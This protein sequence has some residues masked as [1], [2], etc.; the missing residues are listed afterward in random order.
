M[1]S[2][3]RPRVS[4]ILVPGIDSTASV[5]SLEQQTETAWELVRC[6]PGLDRAQELNDALERAAGEF[7]AFLDAGDTLSPE[8]MARAL[9]P[10]ERD[11]RVDVVYTD[12]EWSD[13]DGSVRD[14]FFKP[15]WSPERLLGHNYIGRMALYRAA[16]VARAGGVRDQ[17][18]G[19]WEYDLTL[20]VTGASRRIAHVPVALY[21]H[22]SSAE[23]GL[24]DDAEQRALDAHLR[25][26]G[27]EATPEPASKLAGSATSGAFRLRAELRGAPT[28][29]LII[30]AGGGT[31][32]INGDSVDLVANLVES[33]VQTST[34]ENYELIVVADKD[35]GSSTR[36]RMAA[37]GRD[38]LRVID[39]PGPFN[40]ARKVNTGVLESSGEHLVLLNDDTAVITPDWIESMLVFSRQEEIGAVGVVL[41]FSD[42]RYQHAGVV[43]VGGNPGHPYYGFPAD[44]A[45][46]HENL[47]VPCN[48][49]AVTAACL[50]TRRSVFDEV[51][52]LSPAFPSDYNDVDFCLKVRH[53]GFRVVFTPAAELFHFESSSRGPG[54]VGIHELELLRGRW[55]AVLERDPY[56]N[57]NFLS[58]TA[59]F[60]TP[61][62]TSGSSSAAEEV[63]TQL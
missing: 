32:R 26:R 33:V 31:R 55:G 20:R 10:T 42:G 9:E 38:R 44:F 53:R 16:T 46:Y 8:A 18:S 29:S 6:G 13:S 27:V 51:G 43:A 47:R 17:F 63:D 11:E 61:P 14:V 23:R 1:K 3:A 35:V 40:F 2:S 54:P 7:V 36:E 12:E 21:R 30:P 4:V 41:R 37:A 24:G 28:V 50:M 57:P 52:G 49:L 34:Y 60:L 45:G 15:D 62:L 48:Y 56:Y 59:D 22:S 19:A 25:R 39:F 5:S 58:T